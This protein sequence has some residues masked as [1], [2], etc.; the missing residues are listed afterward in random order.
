MLLK[1]Y[2]YKSHVRIVHEKFLSN[3]DIVNIYKE[4]GILFCVQS[5]STI[6][7]LATDFYLSREKFLKIK[8]KID[9][10]SNLKKAS[11][12]N[13]PKEQSENLKEALLSVA[14]K[15]ID[16]EDT[17]IYVHGNKD[18]SWKFNIS[19]TEYKPGMIDLLN[20]TPRSIDVKINEQGD[21]LSLD[22]DTMGKND[23]KK[24]QQVIKY[25]IDTNPELEINFLE[26]SLNKLPLPKRIQLFNDFLQSDYSPWEIREITKLKVKRSEDSEDSLSED[27]LKGINSAVLSGKN[28]IS[29][30]FV[31]NTIS[32]GFYFSMATMRFEHP[33]NQEFIEMSIDFKSRPEKYEVR[34]ETCGIFYWEDSQIH[35]ESSPLD[36]NIQDE[37]LFNFKNT[38]FQIYHKLLNEHEQEGYDITNALSVSN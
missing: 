37:L 21:L 32:N 9:G 17:K 3:R 5:K 20:T 38:V 14:G 27:Q 2:P 8:G 34:V 1:K 7:K 10:D 23:Y 16:D 35:Y 26:I 4:Q 30:P 6:A 28:L 36:E 31:K 19:Y 25:V 33:E 13:I 22:F 29:N 12:I 11:R 18:G 15:T 24:V